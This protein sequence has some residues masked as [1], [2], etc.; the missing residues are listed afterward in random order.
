[1]TA[2]V[3]FTTVT[4]AI[5]SLSISGVT[6]KDIDN[7][8]DSNK[9]STPLLAPRPENFITD[10]RVER[11]EWSAQKLRLS[12]TLNYRYYHCLLEMGLGGLFASY[13]GFM[14]KLAALVLAFSNDA[15]LA[16]ALDKDSPVINGIG[17]VQ[18]PAGNNY[19]GC[20]VSVHILQFLEV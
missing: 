15:I 12:Y 16:G 8:T 4:N 5:E 17:P 10:V 9:L 18:D 2:T 13:G 7:L 11:D 6:I 19:L 14:T 1:M 3:D 20:V